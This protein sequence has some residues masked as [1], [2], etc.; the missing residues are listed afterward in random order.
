MTYSVQYQHNTQ[1]AMST[2]HQACHVN[3]TFGI[4]CYRLL[5]N[6]TYYGNILQIMIKCYRLWS[7]VTDYGQNKIVMVHKNGIRSS[8]PNYVER[9]NT[10]LGSTNEGF[11]VKPAINIPTFSCQQFSGDKYLATTHRP[12]DF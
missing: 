6:V 1:R 8:L 7:N 5:S 11:S 9:A 4:K 2:R 12:T 10:L 3:R